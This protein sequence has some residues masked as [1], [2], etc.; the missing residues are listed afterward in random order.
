MLSGLQDHRK[1]EYES[2]TH[3]AQVTLGNKAVVFWSCP[4]TSGEGSGL[5]P[6]YWSGHTTLPRVIQ[7]RNVL[8][9]TWRLSEFAWMTHC[10]F[11]Q[12]KFDQ[13]LLAG[14]WAFARVGKGYLGIYSQHGMR[15]GDNGQY[16]GR[17]LICDAEEN[18]WLVECGREADYGSFERFVKTLQ[19]A[20]IAERD[21]IV[22]YS[23]PSIGTLVTGW[24]I[25][26]TVNDEPIQLAGYPLANSPWAYSRFGSGEMTIRYQGQEYEIWF[27]Q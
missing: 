13:I 10:F 6:D 26:P 20:Q 8:S 27:N 23:S 25:V 9:L 15:V 11:E 24:D 14:D 22:E 21:G 18:T 12:N 2:S 7:Y 1:G 16:A 5:R 17:E 4:H 19:S 3:V